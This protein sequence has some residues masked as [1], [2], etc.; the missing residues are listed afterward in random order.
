[1]LLFC[2]LSWIFRFFMKTTNI[3]TFSWR[4]KI[5]NE[6]IVIEWISTMSSSS[7]DSSSIVRVDEISSKNEFFLEHLSKILDMN[8]SI[9]FN[10]F[11]HD[12]FI[13]R[14]SFNL[15]KR[16]FNLSLNSTDVD[17]LKIVFD[18]LLVFSR[19]IFISLF[20]MIFDWSKKVFFLEKKL[21]SLSLSRN[22]QIF[23]DD[24]N[25][26]SEMKSSHHVH[27][28]LLYFSS[29]TIFLKLF[30]VYRV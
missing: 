2:F 16:S 30:N 22:I 11:L 18:K 28:N 27:N 29:F 24:Y 9:F 20:S 23:R 26:R 6:A 5:L 21:L 13:R 3:F 4:D 1:V 25:D 14:R 7:D 19:K 12:S 10:F 15:W 8:V 17:R